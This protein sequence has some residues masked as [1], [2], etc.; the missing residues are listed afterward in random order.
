QET[1]QPTI[2]ATPT[3]ALLPISPALLSPCGGILVL[4]IDGFERIGHTY[5]AEA[6]ELARQRVETTLRN[7]LIEDDGLVVWGNVALLLL[8]SHADAVRVADLGELLVMAVRMHPVDLPGGEQL[9][10]TCSVGW[11]TFDWAARETHPWHGPL[12]LAGAGLAAA[13]ELGG[14]CCV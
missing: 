14:D 8:L 11:S 4:A 6:A 10:L 3:S 2:A 5:G 7:S 9:G 12:A 13:R 1:E